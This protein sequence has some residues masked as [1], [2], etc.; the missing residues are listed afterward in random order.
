[1]DDE[2]GPDELEPEPYVPTV[3]DADLFPDDVAAWAASVDPGSATGKPLAVLELA[4]LSAAGRVDALVATQRQIAWHQARQQRLLALMAAEPVVAGP[5]GE[6][7]KEWVR[8]DV[9]CA[10]RLSSGHAASSL[11]QATELTRLPATV[12]LLDRG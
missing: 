2:F 1:M 9:A 12:D 11:A 8:E 7:D 3:M 5:V 4:R 10:L 6:L